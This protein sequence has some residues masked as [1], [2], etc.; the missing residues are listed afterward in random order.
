MPAIGGQGFL[1][2]AS[3][4]EKYLV[5]SRFIGTFRMRS[6]RPT[7]RT[8]CRRRAWRFA[9]SCRDNEGA[10]PRSAALAA[11]LCGSVELAMPVA[12][13]VPCTVFRAELDRHFA[14]VS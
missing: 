4:T 10:G 5:L 9:I 13:V 7:T 8:A 3:H 11:L 6:S 12:V 1:S 2:L 14:Q